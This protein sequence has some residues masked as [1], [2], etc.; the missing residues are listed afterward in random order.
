M[1]AFPL[2]A[3]SS[4]ASEAQPEKVL[5]GIG[6]FALGVVSG[7]L[8][9]ILGF[10]LNGWIG[11][12]LRGFRIR[13]LLVADLKSTVTGLKNHFPSLGTLQ[14]TV[15]TDPSFIWDST[16]FETFPQFAA[17]AIY[18]VNP[19]ETK[20]CWEFYDTSGRI[21]ET[22]KE[23]NTAIRTIVTEPTKKSTSS[24]IALACLGDLQIQ[25]KAA[26]I[27]GANALKL[28]AEHHFFVQVDSA[29]CDADLATFKA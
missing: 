11:D 25:Y 12:V 27:A 23:Y 8:A 15:A 24:A 28:I 18:H 3:L 26:I 22:R 14:G 2:H 4:A 7:V 6:Q 17:E 9:A 20:L 19:E 10:V 1:F 16:T 21:S 29:K 13:K 5:S